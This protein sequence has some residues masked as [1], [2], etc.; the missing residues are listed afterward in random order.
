MRR[1]KK[2]LQR[3]IEWA[4]AYPERMRA[5]ARANEFLALLRDPVKCEQFAR[6]HDEAMARFWEGCKIGSSWSVIEQRDDFERSINPSKNDQSK[7][8]TDAG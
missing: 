4:K 6:L 5:D 2:D 1:K 7:P 8:A 3:H